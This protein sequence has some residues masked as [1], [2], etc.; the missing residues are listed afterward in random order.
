M[1]PHLQQSKHILQLILRMQMRSSESG[2]AMLVASA[3]SMVLF[4][5][6]SASLLQT[7]IFKSSMTA[8]TDSNSAFYAAESG[9]NKRSEEIRRRFEGFAQPAGTSPT[10][11]AACVAGT[12]S[13]SGDFACTVRNFAYTEASVLK[14]GDR[15]THV[16]E[17]RSP[18][19]AYTYI[20][21]GAKNLV[22]IPT[23][24]FY[25]GLTAIEYRYRI[26]AAAVR[27]SGDNVQA[28]SILNTSI[29]SRVI[30]LF[31]FAVFYNDD[32]EINNGPAMT[33]TGRVHTNANLR[34]SPNA[35]LKFKGDVTAGGDIYQ[36]IG[37]AGG[38]S[39]GGALNGWVIFTN[40]AGTVVK[41]TDN[42]DLKFQA[43]TYTSD[44]MTPAQLA[45]FG[46]RMKS[47]TTRL[48][49][50]A[51][52]FTTKVDTTQP[53]NIGEYYGKADLQLEMLPGA[54]GSNPRFKMTAIKT[55][56]ITVTPG[57]T[58]T[59]PNEG[60]TDVTISTDRLNAP[61]KCSVLT[62]GQ[63]ISLQQ[64]VLVQAETNA[65]G[66]ETADGTAQRNLFCPGTLPTAPNVD[67]SRRAQVVR[68]LQ[69]AIVSQG[70]PLP[71][72]SI[73]T[74]LTDTTNT[75][76]KDSFAA[77]LNQIINITA[78]EKTAL[79][80]SKP[81]N[82][83]AV[84]NGCFIPAPIQYLS[85]A[86]TIAEASRFYDRR[87][88]RD[89]SILQ[90]NLQSLAAWNYYNI[91]VDWRSNT[92]APTVAASVAAEAATTAAADTA[93][94]YTYGGQGVSNDELLFQR[95]TPAA[96]DPAANT[97]RGVKAGSQSFGAADRGEGGFVMHAT[98]DKVAN[99]Y[100]AGQSPY[101]FAL[102]KGSSLPGPL[103]VA[104]DQSIY[105]QGNYN[106]IGD[107]LPA[108]IIA[109]TVTV[110]SNI[111]W[112]NT[113]GIKGS[114]T[115]T[116]TCGIRTGMNAANDTTIRAAFLY[117]ITSS[118]AADDK[119][120]GGVHNSMRFLENWGGKAFN[121]TGSIVSLRNSSEFTR[122]LST[123][124]YSP[125]NRDLS[126]DLNF[127]EFATLP[128]MTPGVIYLNQ[129]GFEGDYK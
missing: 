29:S 26:Y 32:L 102:A 105:L 36:S 108:A 90:T 48:Q 124:Y 126:Y 81:E 78:T 69:T 44:P 30:P 14:G 110:L 99:S 25:S 85:R 7:R 3:L 21:A 45:R 34:L 62:K 96:T 84:N 50:P 65:A 91:S 47:K 80:A 118:I 79:L 129:K 86:N 98:V 33:L 101:A 27:K 82:I 89:I 121:Y 17:T 128:P 92:S 64:P 83:A 2:Y 63:L 93:P 56:M 116:Q 52:S 9:L 66:V 39:S 20:T 31:Q 58:T 70:T 57:A 59:P 18:F 115:S 24:E 77:N 37:R 4:G 123:S 111:C 109:D 60:C 107:R 22:T 41:G 71:F 35:D 23:G 88:Q 73:S 5:L 1:R 112:D 75:A 119:Y 122:H 42:A 38:Y 61:F 106:S 40:D 103:T 49:V 127:N 125:P 72:S 54:T 120:S 15:L 10:S 95:H 114:T 16:N 117:G 8:I 76:V 55:G 19:K 53:G 12:S 67:L 113:R 104:S 68:A 13:G 94:T 6:L 100:T 87:E 11:L 51:A 43:T 74:A 46:T 97:L 28:Q